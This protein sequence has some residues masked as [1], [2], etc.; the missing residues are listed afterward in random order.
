MIIAL[1]LV[2]VVVADIYK[3]KKKEALTIYVQTLIGS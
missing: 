1:F 3:G 2:V